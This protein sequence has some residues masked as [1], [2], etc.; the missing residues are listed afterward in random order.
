MDSLPVVV[1]TG[2]VPTH[3]IGNDA[4]QEADLT[5]IT[6]SCTKHNY[7]VKHVEDLAPTIKEAFTSLRRGGPARCSS[8][9]RK[10][11][12]AQEIEFSYPESIEMRSYKPQ[13][14]G[15]PKAVRRAVEAMI[16]AS[17]P[18][19]YIGGGAI[20]AK[21]TKSFASSPKN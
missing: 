5:G 7:L 1:F 11:M 13:V 2:Q 16:S 20:A 9:C 8:T 19:L 17:R 12:T 18:V 3:L 15:D 21:P 4:F 6:R 10:T 14:Y